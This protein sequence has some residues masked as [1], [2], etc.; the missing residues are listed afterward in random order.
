MASDSYE[1]FEQYSPDVLKERERVKEVFRKSIEDLLRKAH[2]PIF[3]GPS[4]QNVFGPRPLNPEELP[5]E[6]HG[7][8]EKLTPLDLKFLQDLAIR[9]EDSGKPPS[10]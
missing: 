5:K 6:Y 3:D 9:V 7:R 10:G 8:W 1:E 2:G 4:L